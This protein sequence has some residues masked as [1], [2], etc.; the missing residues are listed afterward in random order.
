MQDT[1]GAQGFTFEI[2]GGVYKE[3]YREGVTENLDRV[4]F[5]FVARLPGGEIKEASAWQA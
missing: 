1:F 5:R 3:P 2:S 4:M